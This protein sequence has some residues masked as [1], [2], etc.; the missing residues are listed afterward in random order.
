MLHAA[1]RTAD[2][3]VVGAGPAGVAAVGRLLAHNLRVTWIDDGDFSAGAL[4][5]YRDVPA[6]TK[7]DVLSLG[8]EQPF[9]TWELWSLLPLLHTLEE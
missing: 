1:R 9:C 5:R 6:N 4:A 3:I 2:A 7:V 8:N